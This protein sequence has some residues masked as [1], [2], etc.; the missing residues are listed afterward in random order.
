MAVDKP[1]QE[2]GQFELLS[3]G[4]PAHPVACQGLAGATE[5][6]R[7]VEPAVDAGM[8]G[9]RC[10]RL[11]VVMLISAMIWQRD[12]LAH[13]HIVGLLQNYDIDVTPDP[14]LIHFKESSQVLGEQHQLGARAKH[15]AVI[16]EFAQG[17]YIPM[18][19]D[20]PGEFE[21]R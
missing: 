16:V 1:A 18:L 12:E 11:V 8:S 6:G 5:K 3:Q 9:P 19:C 17:L 2:R 4:R 15:G 13:G 20:A 7:E 10:G 14:P 21:Q